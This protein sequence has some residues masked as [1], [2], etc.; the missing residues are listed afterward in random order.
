[1]VLVKKIL[2]PALHGKS[3]YPCDVIVR[4]HDT[5]NRVNNEDHHENQPVRKVVQSISLHICRNEGAEGNKSGG[6]FKC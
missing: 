4:V 5:G 2:V 1:M 6:L 3:S